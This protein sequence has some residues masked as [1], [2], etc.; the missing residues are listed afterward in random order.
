MFR[1]NRGKGDVRW[2]D[3]DLLL[4]ETVFLG[5]RRRNPNVDTPGK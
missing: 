1:A 5:Q 2:I 3:E 4:M